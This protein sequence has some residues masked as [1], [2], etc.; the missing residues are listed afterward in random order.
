MQALSPVFAGSFFPLKGRSFSRLAVLFLLVGGF[1]FHAF[2]Q[3][4]TILG[5]VSDPSGA[6]ARTR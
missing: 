1:A 4:A 6:P 3:E 2:A 5:T